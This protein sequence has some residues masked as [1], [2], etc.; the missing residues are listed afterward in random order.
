MPPIN[1]P[2]AFENFF[3][4]LNYREGNFTV[5][6]EF[7]RY[8]F[9][10]TIL[11]YPSSGLDIN[12]LLYI[13]EGRIDAENFV[14]PN[15]FI[16]VDYMCK[17]DFNIPFEFRIRYPN[18]II[19]SYY[20][21]FYSEMQNNDENRIELYKLEVPNSNSIK[22]LIFF[23]GF[24]N[25]DI[26]KEIIQKKLNIHFVYAV[27]DGITHDSSDVDR[28][29]SI[30]TIFYPLF[31]NSIGLRFIITEQNFMQI[32]NYINTTD[33]FILRTNLKNILKLSVNEKIVGMLNLDDKKL[34]DSIIDFLG[35]I[36]EK[37]IND[38][39]LMVFDSSFS[40]ELVLKEI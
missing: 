11:F 13:K 36:K 34:K 18:F 6:R 3:S 38:K 24:Y 5:L 23:R 9:E 19:Q 31:A 20:K 22:W 37:K 33:T 40:E 15:I 17:A 14:S 32:K 1:N 16:H 35:D 2:I 28:R 25:E 39:R 29:K 12:D 8:L 21:F 26:L 10:G 7:N 4:K 27:C 30:P